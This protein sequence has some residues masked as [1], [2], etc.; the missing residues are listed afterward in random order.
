MKTID[1]IQ[2]K[3]ASFNVE[4]SDIEMAALLVDN[5]ILESATYETKAA[6]IALVGIIPEILLKPD[7]TEGGFSIKYDKAAILKYYSMLCKELG[8]KNALVEQPK[9][10]NK[11]NLW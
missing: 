11:S 9:V 1:F 7:I 4:L 3:L 5:G 6:K 8:L 10:V 2:A